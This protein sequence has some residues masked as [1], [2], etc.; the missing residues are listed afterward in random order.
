MPTSVYFS[1]GTQTEQNLYEDIIIE[2]LKIYGQDVH[3][4]PRKLIKEDTLFGEDILSQF[5][6]AYRIEMYFE[7]VDG[8]E[9]EKEIMS[10]FGLDIQDEATFVVSRRRFEQLVATDNNLI[11]SS[12]PNEGDLIYFSGHKKM[13]EI[14][15]VDHD[16]PFYEVSNI[17]VYKLQCKTFEY[18]HEDFN[19]GVKEIDVVSGEYTGVELDN[20]LNVLFY[21]MSLEQ[22]GAYN[23]YI[24]QEDGFKVQLETG[25]NL[26]SETDYQD[27]AVLVE[28]LAWPTLSINNKVGVFEKGEIITGSASGAKAYVVRDNNTNI[29]YDL[30]TSVEFSINDGITGDL[31]GS[32][33]DI[34]KVNDVKAFILQEKYD[35]DRIDKKA[36]NEFFNANDDLILDWTE[37]NPFGDV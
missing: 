8:Y 17:P 12:R 6:D 15:F 33:G 21:Q 16:N 34:T 37:G 25:S 26:L 30:I 2:Q 23:E 18:S 20:S 27:G 22:S 31:I 19:T 1:H 5:N 32:T 36:Q 9:G 14:T 3:Y 29:E 10:K 13:F 35:V 11:V 24:A 7:N 4:I 28:T